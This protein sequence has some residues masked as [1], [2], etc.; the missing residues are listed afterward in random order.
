MIALLEGDL[1][2]LVHQP[3]A[4]LDA[5]PPPPTL[6]KGS[7]L[8]KKARKGRGRG[9]DDDGDVPVMTE[10]AVLAHTSLTAVQQSDMAVFNTYMVYNVDSVADNYR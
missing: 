8:S 2:K 4:F 3:A 1:T 7:A 6:Q 5:V 9:A 10:E